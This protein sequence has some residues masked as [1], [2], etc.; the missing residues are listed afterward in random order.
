MLFHFSHEAQI[1]LLGIN[2]SAKTGL[3]QGH[4]WYVA[5]PRNRP[6]RADFSPFGC[7]QHPRVT[8]ES[9]VSL[10]LAPE[11]KNI[12]LVLC[13]RTRGTCGETRETRINSPTHSPHSSNRYTAT[14]FLSSRPINCFVHGRSV[15]ATSGDEDE[16]LAGCA[17][18]GAIRL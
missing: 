10:E 9:A 3:S 18:V 7:S 12:S 5:G 1:E 11:S 15:S 14:P 6:R 2:H 4:V 13:A 8:P 16:S 17:S